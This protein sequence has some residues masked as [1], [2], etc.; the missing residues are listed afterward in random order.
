LGRRAQ[1]GGDRRK[2]AGRKAVHD[3]IGMF[4]GDGVLKEK[5]QG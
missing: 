5:V 3:S 4:N 1:P 2:D